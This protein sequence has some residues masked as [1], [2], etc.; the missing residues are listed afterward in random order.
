MYVFRQLQDKNKAA[1]N[2]RACDYRHLLL[3]LPFILSN[4]L[5]S[6]VNDHASLNRA[7]PVV[8]PSEELVG[9]TN[10][11]VRWYK[12]FRMN[13]PGKTT[14]DIES[15]RTLSLRY[16]SIIFIIL[17][18]TVI[19]P[20]RIILIIYITT[21]QVVGFVH[22]SF[23]KLNRLIMDTEKVYSIKHCHLDVTNCAN[24]INCCWDGR[25]GGHRKWVHLQGLKTNQ[26]PSSAHTLMTHSL[27]KQASQMCDAMTCRLEDGDA[28]GEHWR[29]SYGRDLAPDRT[30]NSGNESKISR[31]NE[32]P[33]M[34][35][36]LNVWAQ[37]KVSIHFWYELYP[38]YPMLYYPLWFFIVAFHRYGV[39]SYTPWLEGAASLEVMMPLITAKSSRELSNETLASWATIK[40]SLC[41]QTNLLDFCLSFMLLDLK[42][43]TY[44]LV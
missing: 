30:W 26:G 25:E 9:V 10:V 38:L 4:L 42:A 36:E 18:I 32:G 29:D 23:F 27:N 33:Y 44:A 41:C 3:V 35:I 13:S 20:V 5:C 24:P 7:S 17:F 8:D 37:A 1:Q 28:H 39:I 15:L 31:D 11:F 14:R 21:Y 6:E 12:M 16:V 34:G 40:S 19:T 2:T 43:W 22:D